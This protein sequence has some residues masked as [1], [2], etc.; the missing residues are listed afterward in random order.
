MYAT[1]LVRYA[2]ARCLLLRR[3]HEGQCLCALIYSNN[4]CYYP[5]SI[6]YWFQLDQC[7]SQSVLHCC[8]TNTYTH[9][10]DGLN[11]FRWWEALSSQLRIGPWV[12]S[13]IIFLSLEWFSIQDIFSSIRFELNAAMVCTRNRFVSIH[14]FFSNFINSLVFVFDVCSDEWLYLWILR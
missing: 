5:L 2:L 1:T 12:S 14:I 11:V 6:P 8:Y 3:Y 9:T 13:T 4:E 7:S 10:H